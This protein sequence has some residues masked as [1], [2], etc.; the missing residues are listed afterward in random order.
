[1]ALGVSAT[2]VLPPVRTYFLCRLSAV[3]FATSETVIET[4]PVD[5]LRQRNCCNQRLH[6]VKIRPAHSSARDLRVL[7]AVKPNARQSSDRSAE[8]LRHPESVGKFGCRAGLLRTIFA[9]QRVRACVHGGARC[10]LNS[11]FAHE[12]RYVGAFTVLSFNAESRADL[13][14]RATGH[15]AFPEL[16]FSRSVNVT[17]PRRGK[18]LPEMN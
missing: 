13:F 15:Q 11:H 4:V 12:F 18:I 17:R 16:L 2:I 3:R 9:S 10:V 7:Q 14:V 5:G 1:M 8:A 6:Y